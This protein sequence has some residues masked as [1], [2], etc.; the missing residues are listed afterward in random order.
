MITATDLT[1]GNTADADAAPGLVATEPAGTDRT[2]HDRTD[3]RLAH[4]GH[5]PQDPLLG[6]RTQPVGLAHRV[7]A[8]SLT[9]LVNLGLNHDGTTWVVSAR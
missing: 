7:A 8:V 3:H 9:Q 1:V 2:A 4:P 5:Q 6:R